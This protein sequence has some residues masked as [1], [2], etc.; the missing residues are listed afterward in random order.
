MVEI[1]FVGQLI[2]ATISKLIEETC[3]LTK[4]IDASWFG[5]GHET[6]I[7]G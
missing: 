2:E 7:K 1:E 3:M 4:I 5:F 6:L